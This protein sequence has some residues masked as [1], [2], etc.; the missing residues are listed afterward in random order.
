VC[1]RA[2]G[3]GDEVELVLSEELRCIEA[4][5]DSSITASMVPALLR[6]SMTNNSP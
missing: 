2:G 5:V 1:S 4:V 3:G 6:R